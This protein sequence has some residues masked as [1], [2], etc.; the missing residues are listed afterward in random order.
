MSDIGYEAKAGTTAKVKTQSGTEYE[1][2]WSA[3]MSEDHLPWGEVRKGDEEW[4]YCHMLSYI[5]VGQIMVMAL[6]REMTSP[7]RHTSR[8]AEILA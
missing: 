5:M 8:V 2:R 7:T 4:T 6:G 3:D 1:F